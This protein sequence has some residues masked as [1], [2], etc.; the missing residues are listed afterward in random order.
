MEIRQLHQ[1]GA[2]DCTLTKPELQE[3][4]ALARRYIAAYEQVTGKFF[5]PDTDEPNARIKKHL[6]IK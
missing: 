6:G 4:M 3:L 5:V 2:P 1:A